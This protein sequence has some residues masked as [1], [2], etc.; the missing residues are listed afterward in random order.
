MHL[1]ERGARSIAFQ[2]AWVQAVD[3]ELLAGRAINIIKEHDNTTGFKCTSAKTLKDSFPWLKEPDSNALQQARTDFNAAYKCYFK[4][5]D[6][7]PTFKSK[8]GKQ[9]YCTQATNN[10]I[11]IEL[12]ALKLKLPMVVWTKY[13]DDRLFDKKTKRVTDSRTKD[14]RYFASILIEKEESTP[15]RAC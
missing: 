8:H 13:R 4:K 12:D 15:I 10:N 7:H 3:L 14:G 11:R 6:K 9:S 1:S 2:D 5:L